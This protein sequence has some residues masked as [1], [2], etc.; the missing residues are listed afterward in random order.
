MRGES[1]VEHACM[2]GD[3]QL[4]QVGHA[5]VTPAHG[6]ARVRRHIPATLKTFR[7]LEQTLVALIVA[8]MVRCLRPDRSKRVARGQLCYF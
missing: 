4:E 5:G 2:G 1:G 3:Q 8:D 6:W 7:F